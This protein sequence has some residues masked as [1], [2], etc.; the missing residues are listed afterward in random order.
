MKRALPALRIIILPPVIAMAFLLGNRAVHG[1]EGNVL[2]FADAKTSMAHQKSGE[3]YLEKAV[4]ARN[5]AA[6]H[7]KLYDNYRQNGLTTIA[8]NCRAIANYY[9]EIAEYYE[10]IAAVHDELSEGVPST[11]RVR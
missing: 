6:E 2:L 1:T 11:R 9:D 5:N 10:A 8:R 3:A 7:R 4:A